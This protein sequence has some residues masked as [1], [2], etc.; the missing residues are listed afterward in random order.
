LE[1]GKLRGAINLIAYRTEC[2]FD[3]VVN[4]VVGSVIAAGRPALTL[5]SK[6]VN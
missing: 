6:K 4:N 5:L 1:Y 2:N 3:D